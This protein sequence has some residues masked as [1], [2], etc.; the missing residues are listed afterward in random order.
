M[1]VGP[2]LSCARNRK[3]DHEWHAEQQRLAREKPIQSKCISCEQLKP[4]IKIEA[5]A[6]LDEVVIVWEEPEN[7]YGRI[8]YEEYGPMLEVC[9]ECMAIDI[10]TI[11]RVFLEYL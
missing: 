9:R 10:G 7:V 1:Y 2:C 3:A 5:R 6:P 11:A 8:E 4:C